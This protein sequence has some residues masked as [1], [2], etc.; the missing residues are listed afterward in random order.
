[1]KLSIVT[2]HLNDLD[3]LGQTAQSL[4]SQFEIEDSQWIVIDGGTNSQTPSD[5]QTFATVDK[6][7]SI[8]VSEADNGIYDA[9]NKGTRAA[10]GDYVLF[11]NAG[12]ELHPGF[13][14]PRLAAQ[15]AEDEPG[16]VW[17]T[18]HERYSDDRLVKVKNRSPGLAWY[19]IPVNHQNVLFRRD[20]L[21]SEPYDGDFIYC[22]DYDLIGR[23]LGQNCSV[24]LTDMPVA[25]FQRGGA[26]AQNF[27]Q[28]MREEELLR[29]R[30]F[31]VNPVFSRLITRFKTFN[32]KA[33][34][35]PAVRRL[36]RKWV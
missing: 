20:L 35:I 12:D 8:F 31:G 22:A 26:S 16:M 29:T 9:M 21:G 19:G 30:H 4:Q 36:M 28:T 3:G 6:L 7:A 32:H 17:G 2:V 11:L 23:L 34:Q 33:G 14:W 5:S 13:S 27:R 24:H 1:V 10:A 25:I 18:C 15:I